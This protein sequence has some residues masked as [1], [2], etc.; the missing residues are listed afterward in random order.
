MLSQLI[1]PVFVTKYVLSKS[2]AVDREVLKRAL[3]ARIAQHLPDLP[4]PYHVTTP[5]FATAG[6]KLPVDKMY[7]KYAG[8]ADCQ[9]VGAKWEVIKLPQGQALGSIPKL[10]L[11][12]SAESEV[13]YLERKLA[14]A[15]EIERSLVPSL[16]CKSKFFEKFD[17]IYKRL[18]KQTPQ[19]YCD[20][21]HIATNYQ[22]AKLKV[23]Q[24]F[25][26]AGLGNWPAK[27]KDTDRFSRT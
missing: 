5:E 12:S 15:R 8:W 13:D 14:V 19:L 20:V 11:Q 23:K 1:Q 22:S 26:V 6:T 4:A 24:A 21:K 17:H 7:G 2:V 18:G 3:Y 27:M 9:T 16:L 10:S 25:A